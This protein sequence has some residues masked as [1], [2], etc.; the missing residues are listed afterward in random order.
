M[1]GSS[2]PSRE[3]ASPIQAQPSA[4]I[5]EFVGSVGAMITLRV[6]VFWTRFSYTVIE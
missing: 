6:L 2:Y 1:I 3:A 4:T 5:N